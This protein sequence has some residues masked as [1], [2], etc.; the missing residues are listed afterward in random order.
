MASNELEFVEFSGSPTDGSGLSGSG[1][2]TSANVLP[3]ESSLPANDPIGGWNKVPGSL[4][5]GSAG[6][7]LSFN[8]GGV[9]GGAREF[10]GRRGWGWLMEESPQDEED[11]LGPLVEELET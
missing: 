3:Q 6:G 10:L 4:D 8:E 9:V 1:G 2:G 7:G 11:E 5:A